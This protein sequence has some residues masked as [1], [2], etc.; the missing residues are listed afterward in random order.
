VTVALVAVFILVALYLNSGGIASRVVQRSRRVPTPTGRSVLVRLT[1]TGV[2]WVSWHNWDLSWFNASYQW[3]RWFRSGRRTWRV[4]VGHPDERWSDPV[5]RDDLPT[6]QAARRRF[7]DIAIQVS[8][9]DIELRRQCGG[10][11]HT[12]QVH[13]G[14]L[15]LRVYEDNGAVLGVRRSSQGADSELG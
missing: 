2:H 4:A 7:E 5:Y 6:W 1:P 12:R 9:G 15:L 8:N 11:T 13:D 10:E 3:L 14:E